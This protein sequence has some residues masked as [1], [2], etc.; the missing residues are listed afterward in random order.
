MGNCSPTSFGDLGKNSQ[1]GFFLL[2]VVCAAEVL[3]FTFS[4]R[5]GYPTATFV[6][7]CFPL[8][9][10]GE[11]TASAVFKALCFGGSTKLEFCHCGNVL[12][13][14]LFSLMF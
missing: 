7:T 1:G 11:L 8:I 13:F 14:F 2:S 12:F 10:F 5:R 6:L 4:A 9:P 3:L